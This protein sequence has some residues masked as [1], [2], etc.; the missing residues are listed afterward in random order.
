MLIQLRQ[1]VNSERA[2][3]NM[4]AGF[5]SDVAMDFGQSAQVEFDVF[6]RLAFILRY[7]RPTMVWILASYH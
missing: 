5:A 4:N 3:H 6:W 1:N 7:A 2:T